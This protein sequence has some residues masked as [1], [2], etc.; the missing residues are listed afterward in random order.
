MSDDGAPAPAHSAGP[1]TVGRLGDPLS[2]PVTVDP[3][4]G[5]TRSGAPAAD[6]AAPTDGTSGWVA[7]IAEFERDLIGERTREG[8][9]AARD[10]GRKGGRRPVLPEAK[11]AYARKLVGGR[12][13]AR[14]EIAELVGRSRATLYR[15]LD[16]HAEASG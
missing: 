14:T 12:E 1:P 13:H 4:R 6:Y 11:V 8:L 5:A 9:A 7:S 2:D 3:G 10:R 16:A 15:V